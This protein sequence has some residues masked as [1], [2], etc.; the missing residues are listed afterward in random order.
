MV[1]L[2]SIILYCLMQL[3]NERT[4]YSIYH[5]LK[6]K[7]S[8]Q[9]IQD[10]HLF[11]LKKYFG[12][13]DFL[14]RENFDQIIQML[15]D[16]KLIQSCGLQ[17]FRSTSE[18]ELFLIKNPIP[19]DLNGWEFHQ[20]TARFWARL[21]LLIQVASNLEYKE[22]NYIPIQ[23]DKDIHLWLKT[24]LKEMNVS[25]KD[26]GG[27]L[28]D[29]LIAC[30]AENSELDPSVLVYRLTG[31][32]QIGLTSLQAAQKLKMDI[33][34]YHLHFINILHFM[35]RKLGQ[36]PELFPLLA[37]LHRALMQQNDLTQSSQKT[38]QLLTLGHSL[39]TIAQIRQLKLST[40]EDHLVE[41]TLNFKDFSI[42][43][44]VEPILQ[45]EILHVS[46]LI[47]SKQLKLI[48]DQVKQASYFQ[49]RLVLAKYGG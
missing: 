20:V 11:N 46:K 35:I 41:I 25:K 12:I 2:E 27:K 8:S 7:K 14:S 29:E 5:L 3:N 37:H 47:A 39:E 4:I 9:T 15:Q 32:N 13:Y 33:F 38:W 19:I 28:Y 48:K 6:G 21:S 49:I 23:K 24:V 1:Q 26:M 16:Q 45:K 30:F 43:E 36:E 31:F 10:A 18:G 34:D 22:T 40:I 44:Y 42:N 17:Q